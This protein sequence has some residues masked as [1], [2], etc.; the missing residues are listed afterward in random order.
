[1]SKT[2]DGPPVDPAAHAPGSSTPEPSSADKEEALL[3]QRALGKR[4][5][6]MWEPVIEEAIPD[7]F[8]ALLDRMSPDD[9]KA[10]AQ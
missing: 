9:G 7:D 10:G 8:Q 5:K 1:M 6:S 4:L 2:E 3:R